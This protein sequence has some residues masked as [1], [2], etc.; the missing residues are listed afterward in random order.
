MNL[1]STVKVLLITG[2]AHVSAVYAQETHILVPVPIRSVVVDD[3]FWSPKLKTWRSVTL[4]DV[5]DKFEEAGAFRNFDRVAGR[6]EGKHEG[7]PWFD[8]LIYETIRAASDFLIAHPDKALEDRLDAYIQRIADAQD[9]NPDGYVLTYTLLDEPGHHWGANGG[10]LRWQHDLYNAGALVEAGVHHCRATGKV[11][12]LRVAVKMANHM[13]DIMGPSPKKN[14]VPSHSLPEESLVELYLLFNEHPALKEKLDI[15]VQEKNYLQLAEF[16]LE[17]RGH[18]CGLPTSE[19]WDLHGDESERWVREQRYEGGR[20]SWGQYAQDHKSV[21]DQE[22][23]EG[24]AVRAALMCTGLSAAARVNGNSNYS[25]AATRLWENMVGKRLHI[26]GGVGAFAHEEKFGPDYVLPNDAYLETCAAAAV[27]FFHR[28][29]N[30]LSGDGRYIDELERVL[31]NNLLNGVSLQGNRYFYE[32]PLSARNHRRWEWHACPCCPPM[33]LKVVSA[34]PGYIYA[35]DSDGIYVNLFIGSQAEVCLARQSVKVVQKT[36][37]PWK[38]KIALLLEPQTQNEFALNIRIP[39]W[40][41][42]AENPFGLYKSDLSS[43]VTLSVNGQKISPHLTR[44]Y[45]VIKRKWKKGDEV[46]L[47]LPM[48]PRR[49]YAHPEVKADKGRFALQSGPVV[50]CIEQQDNSELRSYFVNLDSQL[51]LEHDPVLFGGVNLVKA[52]ALSVQNDTNV[53]NVTLKAIP[54]YCQDNHER[55][56]GMEVW[57]PEKKELAEPLPL[58]AI[59]SQFA[60]S[61]SHC[62][63]RDTANAL[64]DGIEPTDSSDH[65]IPRQTWWDH[66][67]TMEWVQY[68]FDKPRGISS[69][70]VYWWDDRP[71][72]GQCAVPASWRLLFRDLDGQWKSVPGEMLFGTEKDRFNTVNFEPV[73]ADGLRLEVQLSNRYSGGIL[74]W[75]VQ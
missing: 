40:A 62:F 48:Q 69:A 4:L 3:P 39:G 65:S 42:G 33:F 72:G 27:G 18:H 54:F 13:A 20:P 6:L 17:G 56:G 46:M 15:P 37:Y 68:D 55:A 31:Y 47:E 57:L 8:G 19:Q 53:K 5:L 41:R 74:E 59:A 7:L 10:F 60:V 35:H 2:L 25:D 51:S 67:G 11:N 71:A 45:A 49:V 43:Q 63:M 22:T 58:P 73:E 34:L 24:H 44:G 36:E 70:S 50:Y 64:N 52:E 38:G 14:I 61:V 12:L 66:R 9:V 16:W 28:N 26:T 21:F 1:K 29:M 75:T 23:I 32:N 30:L